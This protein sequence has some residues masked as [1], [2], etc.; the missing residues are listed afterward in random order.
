MFINTDLSQRVDAVKDENLKLKSE[1][2]V[3]LN[4]CFLLPLYTDQL[5]KAANN[6]LIGSSFVR[7]KEYLTFQTPS[8][9]GQMHVQRMGIHLPVK[10][11]SF[12]L[13]ICPM[14]CAYLQP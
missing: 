13:D 11:R 10:C 5:Y 7:P 8:V 3:H 9:T 1:N 2:Q 6:F 4:D 12:L 14:T